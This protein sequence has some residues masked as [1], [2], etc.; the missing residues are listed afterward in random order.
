MHC[1]NKVVGFNPH[2]ATS[3]ATPVTENVQLHAVQFNYSKAKL[4]QLSLMHGIE[5]G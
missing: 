3:V 1:E 4:D 5:M 2:K